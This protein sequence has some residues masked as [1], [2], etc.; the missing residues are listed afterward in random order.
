[1]KKYHVVLLGRDGKPTRQ[2]VSIGSIDEK[3]KTDF[4]YLKAHYIAR[5]ENKRREKYY[6]PGYKTF[7]VVP[8]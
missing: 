7:I 2:Y 1:V 4:C 3:I 5:K 6:N 8:V